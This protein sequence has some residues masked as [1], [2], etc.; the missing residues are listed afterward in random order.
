MVVD[1]IH[2][3]C[4]PTW[5]VHISVFAIG[6]WVTEDGYYAYILSGFV[7]LCT[8][9]FLHYHRVLVGGGKMYELIF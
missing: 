4:H 6:I 8:K 3:G 1:E 5:H 9:V 2:R 7:H